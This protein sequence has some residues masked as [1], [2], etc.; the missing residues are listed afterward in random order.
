VSKE[1]AMKP[2]RRLMQNI[3][4]TELD[5]EKPIDWSKPVDPKTVP[6]PGKVTNE[7]LASAI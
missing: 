3:E 1:A 2:L 6:T 4:T 7:D 5:S